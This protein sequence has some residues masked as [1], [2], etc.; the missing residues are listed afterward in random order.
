[1]T[2]LDDK[3]LKGLENEFYFIII[4]IDQQKASKTIKYKILLN[5]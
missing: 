2:V 5:R 1:M 3:N 4:L